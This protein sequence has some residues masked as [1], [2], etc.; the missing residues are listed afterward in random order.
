MTDAAWRM[1][2]RKIW[3]VFQIFGR[4]AGADEV[5]LILYEN[6]DDNDDKHVTGPNFSAAVLITVR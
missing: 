6:A 4:I 2:D 3:K 5:I 1:T